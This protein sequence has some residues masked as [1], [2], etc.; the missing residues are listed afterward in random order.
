MS[1]KRIGVEVEAA[2]I[3]DITTDIADN[4][5]RASSNEHHGSGNSGHEDVLGLGL[6]NAVSGESTT[7]PSPRASATSS[8][9][10]I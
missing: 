3:A 9:S 10:S 6:Y 5:V 8:L 7:S 2:D 4:I 1:Q